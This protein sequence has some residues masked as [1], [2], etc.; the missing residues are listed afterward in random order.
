M[1]ADKVCLSIVVPVFN[2]SDYIGRCVESLLKTPGIEKTEIILVDDGSTDDSGTI[3]DSYSQ[4][5]EFITCYHKPNGGL[6]DARNYGLEK[7]SGEYVFFF[8]SDDMADPEGMQSVIDASGIETCDMILWDGQAVDADGKKV[9]SE[10]DIILT[11]KGLPEDGKVLTGTDVMVRLIKDHNKIANTAWLRACRREFLT[12]NKLCF[13]KGLIHEDALW[14]PKAL[15]NAKTVKYIPKKVYLYRIRDNSIARPAAGDGKARA[16]ALIYIMN[17][18]YDYYSRNVSD[19]KVRK[20]LL[21]NW[22][23]IYMWEMAEYGFDKHECC[24]DIPRSK[25]F[26]SCSSFKAEIKGFVLMVFGRKAFCR[27]YRSHIDRKG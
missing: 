1:A 17:S 7:A 20:I 14:T 15:I 19:V 2:V 4:K 26:S 12:G 3:A 9:D 22:A 27:M 13:E 10:S 8:D 11:H 16:K 25:I 24:K 6:S 18:L 21:A 23:E 5:Y